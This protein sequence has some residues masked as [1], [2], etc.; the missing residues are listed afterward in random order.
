MATTQRPVLDRVVVAGE[1][2]MAA[3]FRAGLTVDVMK[4]GRFR[5]DRQDFDTLLMAS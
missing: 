4:V 5:D 1:L 3:S 2:V